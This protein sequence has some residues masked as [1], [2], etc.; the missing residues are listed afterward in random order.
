VR[1]KSWGGGEPVVLE[2][3][4]ADSV[5]REGPEGVEG[6]GLCRKVVEVHG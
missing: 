1:R 3:G 5:K 6:A 2:G 4:K